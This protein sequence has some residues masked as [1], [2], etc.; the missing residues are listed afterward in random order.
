MLIT[1]HCG[2][3]PFNGDTLK[4][5][6]LGGSETAA[7]YVAKEL[8]ARGHRVSL[9]TNE[10][11]EGF[12]DGVKYIWAGPLT[13]GAPLGERFHFYAS[14]TPCDVLLMQRQP[15]AFTHRFQSK[16]NICWLH[17][18]ALHRQRSLAAAGLWNI[19]AFFC[20]SEW[21][22]KQVCEVY[23]LA[24]EIVRT[25]TNGVDLKLFEGEIKDKLPK[26]KDEIALLYSSRPER[27][28]E[29][30][31]RPGGIMDRLWEIDKRFRLYV[32]NYDNNPPQLADYYA[33]LYQRIEEMPNVTALGNLTKL[34]LAD[35][36]RQC[37]ALVYPTEFE[38]V[39]C[40]T[41]MEAMAAGLPFISSE[42]A[43]LPETCINSGSI[44]L[45]LKSDVADEDAFIEELREMFLD[46]PVHALKYPDRPGKQLAHV[47]QE[48]AA[49]KFNWPIVAAK[50]ERHFEELFAERSKNPETVLKGLIHNSDYY[51]AEKYQSG[52]QQQLFGQD[53]AEE[54]MRVC[55]AFARD[56]KWKEHYEAYYQYEKDRGVEYGP[57]DVTNNNRYLTVADRIAGL[58]AGSTVCDYGCA[59]GHYTVNLAKQFPAL[60]F[61]GID[62]TASNITIARKWAADEAVSNAE[63]RVGCVADR[64][65][66][67]SPPGAEEP[68]LALSV[69]PFDAII[70]A[71]VLEHVE[72]PWEM[73]DVLA[74][75]LKPQGRMITTT[76][77]GPWE[78]IGYKEHWPWRAHVHHLERADLH[79]LFGMHPGFN[80]QIT[81]G[82]H[83]KHG[84]ALGSYVCSFGKPTGL[85]GRIDYARKFKTLAP[86]QTLAVCIIAKDAEHSLGRCLESVKD[87]ADEIIVGVD[88]TTKD[89]TREIARKYVKGFS[90][91]SELLFDINSPMEQGFD[92][93]RNQ[94]IARAKADWI[95][96]ID[97]DEVLFHPENVRKYLRENMFNAYAIKQLHYSVE[98]A[99]IMKTDLPSRFFRNGKGIKFFGMVHEHPELELNKGIGHAVVMSDVTIAHYGYSTEAV[100]R[101]RF[102]RNIGLL[103][104][105]RKK[106]PE[107]VLGKFLWLRDLAQMCRWEAE[108]NGGQVSEAMRER[109]RIGVA[110]WEELLDAGQMRMIADQDN[111]GFYSTLVQV[112]GEGFDFGFMLDASKLNGGAHPEKQ[113]AYTARFYSKEHAEKLFLKLMAERI[114]NYDSKYF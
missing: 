44:L 31:V 49:K 93:A 103:I 7:Y 77:L 18:L 90:P 53:T 63:F 65:I 5:K 55:Y 34:Q 101:K 41:A 16:L 46:P 23:G 80:V 114:T 50:F 57:E 68:E 19:D 85:S 48:D 99:G 33:A 6:S 97:A 69:G 89:A 59:H 39:S 104:Q 92:E 88:R 14:N 24:P 30:H 2:G 40:I 64:V 75:Y 35:A 106:Y 58:P 86:A 87:I 94:T 82:G 83:D 11:K 26:V 110:I 36:M 32:C 105:D 96:W 73:V 91:R 67:F 1:M 3:M 109:A 17:D 54:E 56:N 74:Q 81:A 38:E 20:V 84:D 47:R 98:P 60:K 100:R 8:A 15:G 79:D 29:H 52:H 102:E 22:K 13:E 95:L 70:V 72:S 9:F 12:F 42:V 71:E 4:T 112:L 43:A 61:V 78:A 111:L 27:G 51:A 37:D 76:P 66:A 21:H 62:I 107:R 108:A 45:P 113:P 28:L 10:Q 25:V